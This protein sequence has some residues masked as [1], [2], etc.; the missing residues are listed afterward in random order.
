MSCYASVPNDVWS[1]GVILVNLTCGRNPWKRASID[2]PTFRA[3]LKDPYFL[4]TILPLSNEAI[5]VLG[6]IFECDPAKRVT[7]PELRKL[8]LECPRFTMTPVTPWV[9]NGPQQ[10]FPVVT[11]QVPPSF[12]AQPF[13]APQYSGSSSDSSS[14]YSDFSDTASDGTTLTEDCSDLDAMSAVPSTA[15]FGP[16]SDYK[17]ACPQPEQCNKCNDGPDLVMPTLAF[18]SLVPVC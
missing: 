9:S 1:L 8:V 15:G 11:P 10:P 3:Y 17:D 6:R 16:D 5:F 14:H 18:G 7:L 13:M 12:P 2:D 4:Q